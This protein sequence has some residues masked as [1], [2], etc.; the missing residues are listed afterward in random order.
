MTGI[1]LS[2]E[3]YV[4]GDRVGRTMQ[5]LG[6]QKLV[7][8]WLEGYVMNL[9]SPAVLFLVIIKFVVVYQLIDFVF[10][11]DRWRLFCGVVHGNDESRMGLFLDPACLYT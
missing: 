10:C 3:Q 1:I 6:S 8:G 5:F 4:Q 9:G 7:G 2:S 11:F